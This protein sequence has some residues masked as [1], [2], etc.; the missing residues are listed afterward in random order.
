MQNE[1]S[2]NLLFHT[3]LNGSSLGGVV[4]FRPY[5]E[6]GKLILQEH[7]VGE[8]LV[9]WDYEGQICKIKDKVDKYSTKISED[10]DS[11]YNS[12]HFGA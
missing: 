10:L 2:D 9:Y 4:R 12:I 8:L 6:D 1:L 7:P 3:K 5:I 11:L